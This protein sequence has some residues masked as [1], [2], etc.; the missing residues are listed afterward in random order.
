MICGGPVPVF[1]V[2]VGLHEQKLTEFQATRILWM[3]M[4]EPPRF[5][6]LAPLLL[7]WV[8]F[9]YSKMLCNFAGLCVFF[10]HSFFYGQENLQ[11][12]S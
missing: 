11:C 6:D 7:D 12:A 5:E 2:C 8:A 1:A 4:Q 10:G 3:C 9:L